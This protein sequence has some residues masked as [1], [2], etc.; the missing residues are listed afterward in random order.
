M[1]RTKGKKRKWPVVH[2]RA[3]GIDIGS[4]FHVVAVS[5][6][7]D[8]EPVRTF[9]TFTNELYRLA[10]WLK[11]M[12]IATVAMGIDR[13][14]LDPGVRDPSGSGSG[15]GV[16]QRARRQDCSRSQD[17][18]Q[19][20]TVAPTT[21]P[22]R[23]AAREL[24][25]LAGGCSIEG[26]S[27]PSRTAVGL[28][29]SPRPAHAQGADADERAASSRG[30]GCDRRDGAA[31]HPSHRLGQHGSRGAGSVPR[32]CAARLHP[33]PSARPWWA[34][35]SANMYLP[36]RNRWPCMT[37]TR[38]R[39]QDATKRLREHWHRLR[40]DVATPQA[41]LPPPRAKKS[42]SANGLQFDV[43]K[44]LFALLGVDLTQI[45][46]LGPY[47]AVKLVS[48]CGTDMT[49]WPSAKHFTSWLCLARA[50]RSPGARCSP[51][52]LVD[53]RIERLRCCVWRPPPW[54]ARTR[55]SGVL[56]S[57]CSAG[58][59][60]QGDHRRLLG[61]WRCLFYNAMLYGM[62]Y[63]DPGA[64]TMRNGITKRVGCQPAPCVR[65]RWG[66]FSRRWRPREFLRKVAGLL[67][68]N[69]EHATRC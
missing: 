23:T 42:H 36:C 18:R 15:S 20:R 22:V 47:V 19:R 25:S 51:L 3:A 29:R 61:N 35:T 31:H 65:S 44:A 37:S 50:T 57:P 30:V 17:R 4:Q 60:S 28:R 7:L 21:A 46:G 52:A 59:Q 1:A 48:E 12:G 11:G 43:R 66:L 10:E 5:E 8:A 14:V 45:H 49:K 34:T 2:P 41:P 68:L 58:R 27:A 64:R 32:T 55:L 56:P 67:G 39:S 40:S 63:A 16:G 13:G 54:G 9:S 38:F 53:P 24:P 69:L 6:D 26:V 33:R 62:Q